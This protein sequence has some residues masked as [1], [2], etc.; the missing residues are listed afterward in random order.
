MLDP[1]VRLRHLSAFV[2][3][4]RAGSLVRA[5]RT[6]HVTQPAVSK[7]IRELE[8]LLEVELFDRSRRGAAL[9]RF[10]EIFLRHAEAGLLSFREG[11]RSI[12]EAKA[13][14]ALPL[15][16]GALPTV[17]A[18]LMPLAVKRFLAEG[19]GAVP[20]IVTGPNAFL[21][22]QLREGAL[23]IVIG[24]MA[25]PH[26]MDGFIFEPLY[27]EE[28]CFAVRPGHPLLAERP[29][30]PSRIVEHEVLMPP[31]GS[32]I[33]PTVDR[34]F[35]ASGIARPQR[36]IETVSLAFGRSYLRVSDAVWIISE[37]VVEAD[38]AEGTLARLPMDTSQTLGAVGVTRRRTAQ[39]TAALEIFLSEVRGSAAALAG[40]ET[41]APRLA[42][43]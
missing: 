11:A 12:Q 4:A 17:S 28:L 22:G 32:V 35:L 2:E 33:R 26:E 14:G 43:S 36:T 3:V 19:L 25:E 24:R 27:S 5:A 23:D 7:T 18:R 15:R 16:I 30:D 1:A 41:A 9:T 31:P 29:F 37:G 42:R 13:P 6:L 8:M 20:R 10:G 39:M 21:M 38:V 34:L 40:H